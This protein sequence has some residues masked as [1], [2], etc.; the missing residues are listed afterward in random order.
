MELGV[1]TETITQEQSRNITKQ[2]HSPL[3]NSIQ[4]QFQFFFL[5]LHHE[6]DYNGVKA[7]GVC[8]GTGVVPR[9]LCFY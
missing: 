4:R 9:I 7:Q 5:T 2:T 6:I 3:I 1:H 8:G